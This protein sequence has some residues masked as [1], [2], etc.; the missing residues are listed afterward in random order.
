MHVTV[1]SHTPL[2]LTRADVLANIASMPPHARGR[3]SMEKIA[4][5]LTSAELAFEHEI[6]QALMEGIAADEGRI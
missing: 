4:R 5:D 3:R 6:E 2:F 1:S